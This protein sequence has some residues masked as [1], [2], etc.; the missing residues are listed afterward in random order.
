MRNY[1]SGKEP[2]QSGGL[3]KAFGLIAH[4][5]T[6]FLIVSSS[7]QQGVTSELLSL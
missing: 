6:A 5:G 1:M 2:L 3:A 4:A 7:L